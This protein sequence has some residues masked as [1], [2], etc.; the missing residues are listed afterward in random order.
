VLATM[1]I[2]LIWMCLALPKWSELESKL[3]TTS[4]PVFH[5]ALPTNSQ[6]KPVLFRDKNGLSPTAQQLWLAFEIKEADYVTVLTDDETPSV[7]WPDGTTQTDPLM[8]LERINHEYSVNGLNTNTQDLY[9]RVSISVDNVRCNLMRFGPVF[10][11]NTD[12]SINA[13]YMF[14]KG[15]LTT[16]S[17]QIVSLEE[18]DEVLEEYEDGPFMCGDFVS[19]ADIYW[20]PYMERFCAQLPL[21]QEGDMLEPRYGGRYEAIEEWF[22]AME[23]IPCYS[24]R[25]AGDSVS[26]ENV[27]TEAVDKGLVPKID[28]LPSRGKRVPKNRRG[29]GATKLWEE[30]KKKRPYLCETP[31]EECVAHIVRQRERIMT[32]AASE[33]RLDADEVDQALRETVAGLLGNIDVSKLSGNA[34]DVASFLDKQLRVPRDMGMI[35]AASL[36]ALVA[37]APKPRIKQR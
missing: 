22:A 32:D 3:P 25:I 6:G 13:P 5:D 11:R 23:S 14:R 18:T 2:P 37:A 16:R 19:A 29:D 4:A 36:R 34:R 31:E 26:W 30:Y 10:P 15:D 20:A 1:I 24:C 12:P 9:H 35:P 33:L 8:I 28:L 21:L 27:L 17:S 7:L